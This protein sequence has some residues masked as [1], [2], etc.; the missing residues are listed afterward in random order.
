MSIKFNIFTSNFDYVGAG[1]TSLDPQLL[2]AVPCLAA[3]AVGDWVRMNGA[4]AE[5]AQA[6]IEA[7]ADVIGV[8]EAKPTATTATIRISGRSSAIF[9]GLDATKDYYL[10][11]ATAG[12]MVT[13]SAVPSASGNVVLPLGKPFNATQFIVNIEVGVVRD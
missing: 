9:V 8:V 5:K 4:T 13:E 10:S 6:N 12:A 2:Q 11:A 3:T 7:N 1:A